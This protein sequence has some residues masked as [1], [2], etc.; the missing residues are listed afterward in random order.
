MRKVDL[1]LL[2]VGL[3]AILALTFYPVSYESSS[4]VPTIINGVATSTSVIVTFTG[5]LMTLG[6][7]SKLVEL[8]G[9]KRRLYFT[10]VF[11]GLS[12][13]LLFLAYITEMMSLDTGHFVESLKLSMVGLVISIETF[14][15]FMDFIILQIYPEARRPRVD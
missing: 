10:I 9:E 15:S 7:S 6:I 14:V 12:G 3:P 13:F 2:L 8:Q 1:G 5:L 4:L 11:L